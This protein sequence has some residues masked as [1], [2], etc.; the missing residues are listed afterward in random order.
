MIRDRR[1][2]GSAGGSRKLLER[3][4]QPKGQVLDFSGGFFWYGV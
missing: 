4:V 2:A 3:H 1:F